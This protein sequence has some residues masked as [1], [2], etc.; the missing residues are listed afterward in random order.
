MYSFKNDYSE[1]AHPQILERIVQT[2]MVQTDGYSLDHYTKEAILLLRKR[3]ENDNVDVHILVG[4]TQTNTTAIAAFLRPHQAVMAAETGHIATHETGAIEAIGHKVIVT[5]TEDGK[6]NPTLID[7]MYQH[8]TDEHMVK[9]KMVY[10][11]NPTE[12]GT[13]YKREELIAIKEYCKEKNLYL[14]LDGARMGSALASEKNDITLKDYADYTDAFY[15]GGTKNGAL[16]GEALIICNDELKEEFR[17][18]IKQKGGL[19][20]KGRLLALQFI[21]LFENELFT[22]IG[23]H[24]NDM[25][26]KLKNGIQKLGYSFL[27][28]SYTNQQF[29][30]FPNDILKQLDA[31]FTYTMWEAYDQNHSVIRLV[32]S[33]A[34][35]EEMVDRFIHVLSEL[36]NQESR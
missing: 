9:P 11:S 18:I 34:T 8:H 23:K 32:T 28:D 31:E 22:E 12:I 10:L 6:L 33:W 16:F 21:A 35:K 27:V 13:L 29:P 25:S 15:I 2:N 17:Y 36:T 26:M 24:Q 4:G 14:Y 7:K 3:L 1:G 20:A 19:L 5:N 30:I